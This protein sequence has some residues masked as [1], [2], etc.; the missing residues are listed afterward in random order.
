MKNKITNA[1]IRYL[2]A[3]FGLFLVAVGVALSIL[4]DLGTSPIS[5]PPYVLDL[6]DGTQGGLTTGQ[7]T[8]LMHMVFIIFQIILLRKRFRPVY[9]MQIPAAIV[10]GLLTDLSIWAFSWIHPAGYIDRLILTIVAVA[11]T[12]AGLSIE[13]RSRAWMV[14]GEMTVATLAE[15]SGM[16]FRNVKII[17]DVALVVIAAAISLIAFGNPLGSDDCAV[18]R[19]GTVI[20]ALLTGLLMKFTDPVTEK[21]IGK[22]IDSH[23]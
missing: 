17:F 2:T 7:Y 21:L 4:S 9:L 19:E 15:V 6:C 8:I 23:L 22:M 13:V 18:I 11:V 10:F 20:F 14:A 5:C 12:A 16:K 1:I 3:T